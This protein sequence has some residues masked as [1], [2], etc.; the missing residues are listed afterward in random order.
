MPKTAK[1]AKAS[2]SA[3]EKIQDECSTHEESSSS[4]QEQD[5][6]VFIQPPKTQLLPNMFMPYIEGPK[7]DWTVNDGLNHRFLKQH[8]KCENILECELAM[9]PEKRQC[10]KVIVWSGDFGMDQ[11][12]SW[13]LSI[14]ELTLD[15]IWQKFE[16]F[17]K[18][19]SNEVRAR[20]DLL[21]ILQQG[22]KSVDVWYNAVQTQIA[23][24]N[25]PPETAKI[26]HKDIFWFFLKDEE[27][28]CKTI[29]D[30]N[31]DLGKLAKNMES[32]KATARHIKQVASDPK[33]AQ[34]N[35]MRHQCTDLTAS[36]NR[37]RKPFVKPRP[38]SHKNDTSDR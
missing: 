12:V 24:T 34:I 19:Q 31:I 23:L 11:Y 38:P 3:V 1:P 26:L 21:T 27:F 35:L 16:E 5:P 22:N 8:L 37:K 4:D 28:V 7:M 17:C 36:K 14:D 29:N 30:S 9:S 6:E 13:N 15:T 2:M 20:F 33:A 18:P 10:K 25:Y 32:S